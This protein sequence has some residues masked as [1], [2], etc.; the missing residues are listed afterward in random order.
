MLYYCFCALNAECSLSLGN[1]QILYIVCN[2]I[3]AP[4]L[5]SPILALCSVGECRVDIVVTGYVTHILEQTCQT[6]IMLLLNLY[7]Y[8]G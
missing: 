3:L 7:F 5:L 6:S 4:L 2:K 8:I 1:V